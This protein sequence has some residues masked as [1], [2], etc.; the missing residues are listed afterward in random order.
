MF[1]ALDKLFA[2]HNAMLLESR[3]IKAFIIYSISIFVI[4]MLTSTKQTYNVRPWL[5]IGIVTGSFAVHLALKL[6]SFAICLFILYN[7]FAG[8][9]TTFFMEVSVLRSANDNI[10]QQTWIINMVRLLYMLVASAQIL[11][12]I[13][14][15]R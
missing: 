6:L 14:T 11:Y 12:A 7:L 2:L 3:I 13:C 10:E 1:V 9:C 8:L 15:H 5:Y 4:Y